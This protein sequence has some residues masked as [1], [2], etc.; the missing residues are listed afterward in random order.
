[1]LD[2]D[3]A[4]TFTSPSFSSTLTTAGSTFSGSLTSSCVVGRGVMPA[5][6]SSIVISTTSML[7]FGVCIW[8]S[9]TVTL[10]M[11]DGLSLK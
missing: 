9:S 4:E 8:V 3:N 5:G 2:S 7:A 6:F 1:M 11:A 10:V